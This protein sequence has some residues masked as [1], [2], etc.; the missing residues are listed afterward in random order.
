MIAL[1]RTS[2]FTPTIS[3]QFEYRKNTFPELSAQERHRI[4]QEWRRCFDEWSTL[5][6]DES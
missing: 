6:A 2:T 3:R 1:S 4:A 5:W